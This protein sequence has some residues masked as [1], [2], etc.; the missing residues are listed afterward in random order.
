MPTPS[1]PKLLIQMSGAPGAGKS[2]I[3]ALLR[4][5][6][7]AT[8]IDHDVLRSNL[9]STAVFQFDQ[10]AKQAYVLQ[11]EL[12]RD[13]MKQG[14]D[15][16]IIDSTCNYPEVV[17]QGLSLAV[18]YEYRYWYVECNARDIDLL[19][20]RLRARTPKA[21]QRPAVDC[22][23]ESAQG[24]GAQVGENARERFA[25]WMTKPCRPSNVDRIITADSTAEPKTLRNEILAR[26][27]AD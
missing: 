25:Q 13:F 14:V 7:N 10:A 3:A 16:I 2:T 22:P 5:H 6:L 27:A 18:K 1:T 19:D 9:I 15:S 24:N 17:A 21:S 8:I 11:W 23:L 4:P 26:M 20:K 12:A